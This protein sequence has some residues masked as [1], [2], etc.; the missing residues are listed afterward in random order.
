MILTSDFFTVLASEITFLASVWHLRVLFMYFFV[1]ATSFEAG[2]A[3]RCYKNWL[4]I[5]RARDEGLL[6]HPPYAHT[7][8]VY[9]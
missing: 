2:E 3:H 4:G 6:D 5:V 7:F 1:K 8:Y 9:L